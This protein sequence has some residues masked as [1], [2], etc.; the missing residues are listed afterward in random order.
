[1]NRKILPLVTPGL[2][3]FVLTLASLSWAKTY[4]ISEDM[5]S[6]LDVAILCQI[7]VP[8][9]IT[10]LSVKSV[11]FPEKVNPASIQKITDVKFFPSPR[12]TET[13]ESTDH[14]GNR[15]I[16]ESWFNPPSYI[17]TIAQYRINLVR[18][19]GQ[20]Q[21]NF[22]YPLKS[23]PGEVGVYLRPTDSIQS[24]H[25]IILRTAQRLLNG[26]TNQIQ[27]VTQVL[28]F[29]VDHI[30][31]KVDPL[32][33]DALSTLRSGTGNCQNYA[34]LSAALLRAGGIPARIIT[35]ITADK[36]WQAKTGTTSWSVK[37]GQGR[38]AWLE[39]Y[40]P[41]F[42]WVGYDPQQ[43]LNFIST[44]HI[45]IEA[46][47]DTY[48]ASNDGAIVWTSAGDIRPS[49]QEKI[50]IDFVSDKESFAAIRERPSPRNNLFSTPLSKAALEEKPA[51]ERHKKPPVS[52]YT[53]EEVRHFSIYARRM[54]GNL[55]FPQ[56]INI[57]AR[58]YHE[59][60]GTQ[61]L[62]RS[63]VSE[64]AEY[65]TSRRRFAQKIRIPF[66]VRLYDISCALH[67]FGGERGF[68]W[69]NVLK[70]D[71]DKPGL[72]VARSSRT[73]ISRIGF[74]NGY[75]WIP[76]SFTD[77]ILLPGNHWISLEYSGDAIFNWFYLPGNPYGGAEDTRSSL[78][79]MD[80]WDT[81]HNYDFNFRVRGYELR[82]K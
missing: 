66:P 40:Y 38:H 67:K 2:L 31:Y 54:L 37:L 55:D 75:R 58:G 3:L 27:A 63:F 21:G 23:I 5:A 48:A 41:H 61:S 76:F 50:R 53:L 70:D 1:M 8:S 69:L 18:Y 74:F 14:W 80:G 35:G 45:A 60:K 32:E 81:L 10:S 11:R 25:S 78:R 65:V 56:E 77:D 49:V 47:P 73:H 57:F 13:R 62:R 51:P 68:I 42:G 26:K 22:P 34:H 36:G 43:T 4:V 82:D 33:H 39:V 30:N 7:S 9:G 28:N 52:H 64:T 44:R 72:M 71:Q 15:I 20:F 6:S 24:D 29:V 16:T 46:G 12:P 59:K 19:L 79:S 17:S